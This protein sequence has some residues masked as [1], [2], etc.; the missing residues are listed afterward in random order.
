MAVEVRFTVGDEIIGNIAK[1]LE[2]QGMKLLNAETFLK[3]LF[4]ETFVNETDWIV[5]QALDHAFV[6]HQ[7]FEGVYT[8]P[9]V[10][11]VEDRSRIGKQKKSRDLSGSVAD[12]LE[13]LG[14]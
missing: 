11:L 6:D 2:E 5:E 10:E 13:V 4:D 8:P 1:A 3:D 14:S 9:G 7:G 12:D